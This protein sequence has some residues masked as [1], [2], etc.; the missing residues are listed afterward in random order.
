MSGLRQRF[1]IAP[2]AEITTE[3]NPE[4]VD[5]TRLQ[6]LRRSGVNRLS[7]GVQSFDDADLRFL[8][9]I[10]NAARAEEAYPASREAAFDSV[11]IDLIFGLPGQMLE[12][13]RPSLERAIALAPDHL[14]LYALTVEEGTP[15]HSR[16][17]RGEC[18]ELDADAQADIYAWSSDRL[19]QA[20][21]EHYEISN[22]AKPGH[23]CRHNMTYW[24]C[25]PYLGLGAGA[26]SYV[27]GYRLANEKTPQ[28]Y[29]E[30][31]SKLD[32]PRPRIPSLPQVESSEEPDPERELSDAI[33]L[34]LAADGGSLTRPA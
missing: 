10:H 26:H 4:S 18:P 19:A 2:D 14:S 34:G 30:L 5:L 16:I 7:I 20:G 6:A 21:Y 24:K 8:G 31:V 33:I 12:Q 15:L 9:R 25:R 13:W 27:N 28:K 23:R 17:E 32:G 11:S 3:A 1:G 29:I 22:W